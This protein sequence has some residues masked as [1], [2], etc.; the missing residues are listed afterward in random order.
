MRTEFAYQVNEARLLGLLTCEDAL[1]GPLSIYL[2][3]GELCLTFCGGAC[4]AGGN[5]ALMIKQEVDAIVKFDHVFC[6]DRTLEDLLGVFIGWAGAG[7]GNL[8]AVLRE[9]LGE[10]LRLDDQR[11]P[12]CG[13]RAA[14]EPPSGV[15]ASCTD[16]AYD[17]YCPR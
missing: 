11:C 4:Q 10:Y 14:I 13:H 5:S 12:S 16:A 8:S 17:R 3:Q 7:R 2:H 6:K 15:C 1:C 9:L